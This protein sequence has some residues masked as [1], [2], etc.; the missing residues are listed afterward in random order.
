[1]A[2]GM[3]VGIQQSSSNNSGLYGV[4]VIF[5]IQFSENLQWILRQYITAESL[6]LS[7]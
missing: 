5:L 7:C 1:M 4:T 6:M 2:I 3:E